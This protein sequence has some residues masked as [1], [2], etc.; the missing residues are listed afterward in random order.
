MADRAL[1][2]GV[3]ERARKPGQD[4]LPRSADCQ[5]IDLNQ[6]RVDPDLVGADADDLYQIGPGS[7]VTGAVLDSLLA[8]DPG[9]AAEATGRLA[10]D[11]P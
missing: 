10:G 3:G 6:I 8:L 11:A 4:L 7:Y 2:H 1:E 9:A 5:V